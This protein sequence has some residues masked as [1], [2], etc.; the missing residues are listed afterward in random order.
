MTYTT[1]A[2]VEAELGGFTVDATTN[3]T[4]TEMAV[5]ITEANSEIELRTG[6]VFSSET[7]SSEVYD[8]NHDDNILRLKK[9]NILSITSLE[10]NSSNAGITPSWTSKTENTHFYV[11]TDY[12]EVEII[13]GAFA[14]IS[15]KRRF[16]VSYT[17][18]HS[19]VPAQIQMLATKMVAKRVVDSVINSQA[20]VAGGAVSVGTLS[21][22]DP[23]MFSPQVSKG[24]R[25]E[26]EHLLAKVSG[27]FKTY[28]MIREY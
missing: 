23:S 3:P 15:G 18:G 22:D 11:E 25:D 17:H 10:Y 1:E 7:V 21:V 9:P 4:T 5:W 2:L 26:I 28:R 13:T 20:S 19:S 16:R 8:W 12:G 27:D 24:L 6:E 14:P